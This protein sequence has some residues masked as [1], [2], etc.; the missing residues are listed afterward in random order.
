MNNLRTSIKQIFSE[1]KVLPFSVYTS[2]HVQKL[3]NVPI[4]KPLLIVVISGDKMLGKITR[5]SV[6]QASL[7]FCQIAHLSTCATSLNTIHILR[8]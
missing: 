6:I 3:L 2:V 1:S 8:C 4:L 5:L 7:F